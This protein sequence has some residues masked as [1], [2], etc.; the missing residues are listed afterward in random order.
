M[1]RLGFFNFHLAK[2]MGLIEKDHDLE[3]NDA[4]EAQLVDSFALMIINEYDI[5]NNRK[6]EDVK[7]NEYMAT[8]YLQLQHP[9]KR[10]TTSGDGRSIWNGTVKHKG[11]TWDISSCGTGATKLSPATAIHGKY[12]RSGDPEVSYGCGYSKLSEGF[13]DVV[14]SEILT[15]NKIETERV[16]CVLEFENN[17]SITVR[18]GLNLLRPSHFF[19]QLKQSNLEELRELVDYYVDRQVRNKVWK[20][21]I[22]ENKYDRFLKEMTFTFADIAAKF[23]TFYIFCWM[24]WDGDNI[25]ADG[26]IIDFG[27]VRQFGLYYHE[28]RFDDDDRWSTSIKEQKQKSRY[29]VQSFAQIVDYLKTGNKKGI[30]QLHNSKATVNFDKL[31]QERRNYY[32]LWQLGCNDKQIE[33]IQS[34][35]SKLVSELINS[36]SY[37][38]KYKATEEIEETPDGVNWPVLFNMRKLLRTYWAEIMESPKGL[39]EEHFFELMLANM[40]MSQRDYDKSFKQRI[41]EFQSQLLKLSKVLSS[42]SKM[43]EEKTVRLLHERSAIINGEGRI[44][45]DSV[46]HMAERVMKLRN[47]VSFEKL[48]EIIMELTFSHILNPDFKGQKPE[49]EIEEDNIKRFIKRSLSLVKDYQEGV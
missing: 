25:L 38:E 13:V 6:F 23:E 18:A 10:G 29:T 24:D 5:E 22:G 37:F 35:K 7:E 30:K 20:L 42:F 8:R 40:Y 19:A 1:P 44:T 33:Y 14:F 39:S 45:G 32:F 26:G 28:Y 36:F 47:R 34:K 48:Y 3:M 41:N 21:K 43:T 11:K 17:F 4:L 15:R 9:C 46:C 27:S 2:Q 49:L 12:F 16:L 31:F